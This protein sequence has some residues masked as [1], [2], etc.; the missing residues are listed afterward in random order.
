MK[1]RIGSG[2]LSQSR[3]T[4]SPFRRKGG[5]LDSVDGL[6]EAGECGCKSLGKFFS[7]SSHF[8]IEGECEHGGRHSRFLRKERCETEV[9]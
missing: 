6:R 3:G 7:D 1:P 9:E 5:K 8:L 4:D 2:G